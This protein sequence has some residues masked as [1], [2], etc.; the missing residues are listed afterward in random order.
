MKK[1]TYMNK[2]NIINE[3]ILD[4]IF[5]LIKR[6]KVNKLYKKFRKHPDVLKKIESMKS[7]E[8]SLDNRLRKQGIDPDDWMSQL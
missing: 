5:D 2:E 7:W 3:G 1:K 4:K 6:G 8:K